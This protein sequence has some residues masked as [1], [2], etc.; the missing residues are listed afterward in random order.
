MSTRSLGTTLATLVL[1]VATVLG[2]AQ[3]AAAAGHHYVALGDSYSSGV[4]AGSYTSESGDCK[5]STV[6]YPQLWSNAN[7]PASFKFVAC[8]GATTTSVASSQLSALSS[9]TTL[10]SVT[11]GGNDIG[12]ADVM[13]TCVLQSEATCVAAVNSAVSQMQ[14]SLPGK[15]DSLYSAIR[16]RAPARRAHPR[17]IA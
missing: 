3:P 13:Q 6:A 15:L 11:A 14:N 7:A 16:T 17:R 9:T 2:L 12:F 5:R 4:G 1:G 10:V 8:S